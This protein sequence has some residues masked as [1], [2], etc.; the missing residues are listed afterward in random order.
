MSA[1]LLLWVP[2]VHSTILKLIMVK[3]IIGI[4]S[5]LIKFMTQNY[6]LTSWIVFKNDLRSFIRVQIKKKTSSGKRKN[7]FR[8]HNKIISNFD[9]KPTSTVILLNFNSIMLWLLP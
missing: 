6:F 7:F 2:T 1:W 3:N 5:S 9:L 8:K 4:R